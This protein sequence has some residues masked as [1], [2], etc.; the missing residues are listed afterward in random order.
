MIVAGL[1]II[2]CVCIDQYSKLKARS[3][4]SEEIRTNGFFSFSIVK[5]EGAFRGLLQK[6]KQLLLWIQSASIIIVAILLGAFIH[7]KDR[8]SS[9]GLALVLG[10]AIGNLIDRI[11]DGYVTDFFAVKWTKNL[12][13]NIADLFVFLG[14]LITCIRSLFLK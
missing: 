10:G 14:A 11:K 8:I 3:I 7:K 4:L 2:L 13:Y 1:I 6:N 12:F 5:N 9:I